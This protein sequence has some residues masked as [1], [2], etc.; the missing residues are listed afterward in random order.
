MRVKPSIGNLHPTEGYLICGPV[1]GLTEAPIV[2]H[3]APKEHA[4]E[5]RADLPLERWSALA[6]HLPPGAILVGLTSIHWREAWKYG[7][8]A[9]RYCQHDVGHALAAISIAAAGLGWQARLL[10]ELSTEQ[11]GVLLGMA[12]QA[13]P[14]A[15]HPDCLAVIYPQVTASVPQGLPPVA[16]EA[17]RSLTWIGSPNAL[18]PSHVA[19]EWVDAAAE[20]TRKPPTGLTGSGH[21][22]EQQRLLLPAPAGLSLRRIIHQRRSAQEMDGHTHIDRETFYR[23]LARTLPGPDCIPFNTLPSRP[24]VHLALFVHRITGL[25]PGLYLLVRDPAQT[26]DLR[27]ALKAD[28][29]WVTPPGCPAGLPLYR[30]Q[31]GD[32]TEGWPGASRAARISP[33]TVVSAWACWP[34]SSGRWPNMARG[35]IRACSGNAA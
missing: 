35:S 18:S 29:A 21:R 34:S 33:R 17:F 9:Y 20:A 15:E 16:V 8:R 11:T 26:A 19:W 23:I 12:G 14:D 31:T 5:V 24:Y 30:L 6:A 22:L 13:G 32:A 1:S 10:D 2:A 28:F 7:Q 27:M 3:Y 4:L 25:E